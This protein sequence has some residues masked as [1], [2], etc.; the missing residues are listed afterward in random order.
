MGGKF[1]AVHGVDVG[2]AFHNYAGE[3]VGNGSP[4]AERMADQIASAWVAR[5]G[6]P[7]NLRL[8]E[9]PPYDPVTKPTMIFEPEMRVEND[10]LAG[11]RTFWGD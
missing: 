10:P 6:D 5:S 9:W 2:L 1:G 7:N 4:E 8:R 3:I 11:L